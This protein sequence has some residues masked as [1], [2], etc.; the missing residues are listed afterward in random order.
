MKMQQPDV[1]E[2]CPLDDPDGAVQG[3]APAR[4]QSSE[5]GRLV[6]FR[7]EGMHCAGCAARLQKVLG[8]VAGVARADVNYPLASAEVEISSSDLPLGGLVEATRKAGFSVSTQTR[9]YDIE[10]MHC[11]SCVRGVEQALLEIDG[12]TAAEVSLAPQR[13]RVTVLD[14][15]LSDRDIVAAI[16]RRGYRA[17]AHVDRFT[18]RVEEEQSLRARSLGERRRTLALLS[19]GVVLSFPF[20]VQMAAMALGRGMLMP[21]WLEFLLATPVLF[22]V[23]ARFF[24]SA[25]IA[26]RAGS[27]N[28]DT[29]VVVGT[30]AAWGYSV[31]GWLFTAHGHALYFEAAAMVIT[32]V[33]VGKWLEERAKGAT[34]DAVMALMELRPSVAR[35]IVDD[36]ETEV[37]ID[38]IEE[39]DRLRVLPGERIPADGVVDGGISDVDMSMISGES[40]PVTVTEGAKVTG[41]AIN[42]TGTI[43]LTVTATGEDS[44]LARIIQLV[45]S[46]QSGKA[47]VQRL[48]DRISAV[49]V[50][51]V[52]AGSLA[53]FA[54]WMFAGAT[55]AAAL[56]AAIAV[57]VIACPC[58]LG[59]ATPTALVTGM[60]VAARNGILV[61]DIATLEGA[62]RV[63]TL[64]FDKTG[65][66]TA[67][68]P[69]VDRMVT[70]GQAERTEILAL[71]ASVQQYSEHPY[72]GALLR[73]TDGE[74]VALRPA[75]EFRSESGKGVSARV[76]GQQ[77]LVGNARL[78]ADAGIDVEALP[79]VIAGD[80]VAT[81]SYVAVD[82]RVCVAIDFSDRPRDEA[83][84]VVAALERCGIRTVMLTGDNHQVAGVIA[85]SL[86]IGEFEAG[87]QPP[88]KT[89]WI[90]RRRA[91]GDVVCMVGDGINDAPALAE[92]DIGIAMGTGTDI[93]KQSADVILMRP[94]LA[95]VVD[96]FDVMRATRR[97]IRQNLFWAFIY[98]V[99]AI[100]FAAAGYLTPAVAGAAMAM[101]SVSV[102]SNSLLL[103]RW[104]GHAGRSGNPMLD[105]GAP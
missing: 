100:P 97:K 91:A 9:L 102:V 11:A 99:V 54:V 56:S 76:D 63:G 86:G 83:R 77:V 84:A 42:Q 71:A 35:R 31:Y 79:D 3:I 78:L 5:A 81:R 57:V 70:A 94:D 95:L 92:A 1:N 33:M 93:A 16:E 18:L 89:A 75:T 88:D 47:G 48:V 62:G 50:P 51:A 68:R 28:M 104:R 43:T 14:T 96:A 72:A 82:G 26:L 2:I 36:S 98:N 34:L 32:L 103:R 55:V 17:R 8:G 13:A 58:A 49:F 29:L 24:K 12:V 6:H 10:G 45:E 40:V 27:A 46:A 22:V 85:S 69:S 38:R 20:L 21:P 73:F 87:L 25:F 15:G 59:L 44:M 23:G 66:L 37:P 52:L 61:R 19:L 4:E 90:A 39:G 30:S 80:F 41:G 60:G 74:G 53:T 105:G 67:G 7:I 65:T 64:V 101:S